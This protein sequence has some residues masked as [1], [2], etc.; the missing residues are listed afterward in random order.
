LYF[1]A[2]VLS[3]A[4]SHASCMITAASH[5]S[6]LKYLSAGNGSHPLGRNRQLFHQSVQ[7]PVSDHPVW[8]V[9]DSGRGVF[10]LGVFGCLCIVAVWRAGSWGMAG[11][12]FCFFLFFLAFFF[13]G[14][15]CVVGVISF[16]AGGARFFF[17]FFRVLLRRPCSSR[18]VSLRV[19]FSCRPCGG[20]A[21]QAGFFV[22]FIPLCPCP[23]CCPCSVS[24]PAL[25]MC[26]VGGGCRG[27]ERAVE[28]T[29]RQ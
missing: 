15:G 29:H 6:C 28:V 1:S 16:G 12:I 3:S 14:G 20:R 19:P 2:G 17:F 22:A 25:P 13:W 7:S 27:G 26:H 23:P 11:G 21:R 9:S 5:A 18:P 24:P 4:P 10:L 8:C